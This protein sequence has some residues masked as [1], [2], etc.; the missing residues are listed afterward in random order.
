MHVQTAVAICID[1]IE[2]CYFESACNS[3]AW[4]MASRPRDASCSTQHVYRS[5]AAS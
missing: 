4:H 3:H 2:E 5:P 1:R